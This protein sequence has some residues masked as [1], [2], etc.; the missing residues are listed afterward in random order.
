[1][2]DKFYIQD[3]RNY[4]G[5]SMR[6]WKHD[7]CGY[8][9]DIRKARVFTKVEAEE[10]CKRGVHLKC[11]PKEFIDARVEHHVSRENMRVVES[12]KVN[13]GFKS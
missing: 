6:W 8:V 10:I 3:C 4:V 11:W 13:E 2:A 7:N 12:G 5:N 9:C 1:M